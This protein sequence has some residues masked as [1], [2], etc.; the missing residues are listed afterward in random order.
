MSVG[1]EIHRSLVG[2]VVGEWVDSSFRVDVRRRAL[3][4][5]PQELGGRNPFWFPVRRGASRVMSEA[6]RRWFSLMSRRRNRGVL[7][8]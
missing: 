8:G 2:F 3:A 6:G 1:K 5:L 4:C 7:L